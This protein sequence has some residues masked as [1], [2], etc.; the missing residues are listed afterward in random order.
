M[1]A[2][3]SRGLISTTGAIKLMTHAMMG[4]AFGLAF[5]LTLIL[6]NPTVT[7]LLDHSGRPSTFVF[8]VTLVTTFS[9]GAALTG[10]VFILTEDNDS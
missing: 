10:A 6:L 9:I 4:A 1:R 5:G 7:T 8:V 2:K 3:K